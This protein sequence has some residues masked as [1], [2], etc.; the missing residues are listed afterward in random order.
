MRIK[1]DAFSFRCFRCEW[2]GSSYG[3]D[4]ESAAAEFRPPDSGRAMA[5]MLELWRNGRLI[6]PGTVAANYLAARDCGL[7]HPEGDLRWHPALGIPAAMSGPSL[8]ALM[9]HA[10]TCAPLSLHRTWIT[11]TGKA[12][13]RRASPLLA[14]P[15]AAPWR[16]E[17]VARR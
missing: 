14:R 5:A 17:A 7:P 9:T 16:R 8:L 6:E 3:V 13:R 1:G 4:V 2:S 11:A 15:V 12:K 10:V